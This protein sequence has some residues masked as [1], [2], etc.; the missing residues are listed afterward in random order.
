[1][2]KNVGKISTIIRK[3]SHSETSMAGSLLRYGLTRVPGT[4]R[5]MFPY[6]EIDGSYRTGL[7]PNARYIQKIASEEERNQEIE[8]VKGYLKKAQEFYP[9][10]D[11]GP[12]SSFY[13]DMIRRGGDA[14]VAPKAYLEDGDNLF[15]LNDPR[16]LIAYAYLRVHPRIAPSAQASLSSRFDYYV[17]DADIETEMK[18]KLKTKVTKAVAKL[19]N[20]SLSKRKMVARQLNLGLGNEASEEA[21]FVKLHDFIS[22]IEDGQRKGNVDLFNKFADMKDEN[23][24]IRDTIKQAITFN[25][26]RNSK[27][28]LYRGENKVAANEE[29]YV[30]YLSN[31][32]NNDELISIQEELKLKKSVLNV[33]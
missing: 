16:Q 26:L 19:E 15:D 23:L 8:R 11:L 25:I 13:K 21:V 32:Q 28:A 30:E 7:D 9:D 31:P 29:D 24:V 20:M 22:K 1:M 3:G 4:K 12:R 17:N 6:K 14:D 33:E 18:Y 27:Y 2:A 10:I 5:G